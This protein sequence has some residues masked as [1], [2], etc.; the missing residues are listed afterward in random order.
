MAKF[1]FEFHAI[2]DE[3]VAVVE[4]SVLQYN[5]YL[6]S[7][8]L[9]P[10]FNCEIIKKEEFKEKKKIIYNSKMILLY[11]YEPNTSIKN[12]NDFLDK[13]NDSLI[14]EIGMQKNGELK[15]SRIS[16]ITEDKNTF[17]IWKDILKIFKGNML[18]GAWVVNPN[19]G[20]AE[21]YKNHHYT[22]SAKKLFQKGIKITPYTGWNQYILNE[23]LLYE[24]KNLNIRQGNNIHEN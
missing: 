24:V 4:N 19:N 3:V 8:Q 23:E 21:Y 9:F 14:I 5:L 2:N 6:V 15:E 12:Y 7:I 17:K 16:S 1:N 10:I 13:N 20:A 18:K 11:N 22:A